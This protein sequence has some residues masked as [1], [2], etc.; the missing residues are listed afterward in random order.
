MPWAFSLTGRR[1]GSRKRGIIL[2]VFFAI[3]VIAFG[4][5]GCG[6]CGDGALADADVFTDADLDAL[7]G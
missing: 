1:R 6:E 7:V 4:I 5:N 2:M 3:V